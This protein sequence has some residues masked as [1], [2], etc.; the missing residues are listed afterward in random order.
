MKFVSPSFGVKFMCVCVCTGL[1]TN[2]L[3]VVVVLPQIRLIYH[4]GTLC[5][6]PPECESTKIV[7]STI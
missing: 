6:P 1:V 2:N 3:V 7:Q 4:L 5:P